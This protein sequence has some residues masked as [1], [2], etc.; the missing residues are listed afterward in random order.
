ML[1]DAH[2][3]HRTGDG[4][5]HDTADKRIKQW[6]KNLDMSPRDPITSAAATDQP[7]P[8]SDANAADAILHPHR[9][10]LPPHLF[11]P[12]HATYTGDN[13]TAAITPHVKYGT[14]DG[15]PSDPDRL[16]FSNL[17][18]RLDRTS[19]G[20]TRQKVREMRSSARLQGRFGRAREGAIDYR[21]GISD[22]DLTN[23]G[24]SSETAEAAEDEPFRG[25]R[26]VRGM[27]VLGA[28]RGAGSGMRAWAGLVEERIQVS[29]VVAVAVNIQPDADSSQQA[30]ESGFFN[31]TQGRGAPLV[32]DPAEKNPH[33]ELSEVFM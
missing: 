29:R 32:E 20:A 5:Q 28:K 2:K 25:N 22:G 19:G 11:R 21:L 27:S 9:T 18:L 23:V 7:A 4:V 8:N 17:E 16:L 31:D 15:N 26:Q 33:L 10:T 3:P 12:W 14:I 30:K 1:V 13:Q 6:M 24:S